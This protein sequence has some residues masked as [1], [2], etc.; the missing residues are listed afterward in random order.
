MTHPFNKKRFW[1][2]IAILAV[3]EALAF[4][5]VMQ[6]KY[7]F[8]SHEV[9]EIYTSYENVKGIDVSFIKDFQVNDTLFVDVTVLEATTDSAWD[10]LKR[11]FVLTEAINEC[12]DNTDIKRIMAWRA[13]KGKP[14]EHF[15]TKKP[16][17]WGVAVIPSKKSVTIFHNKN[18]KENDVVSYYIFQKMI[19]N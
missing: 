10:E 12:D 17:D 1:L 15:K 11:D 18:E 2:L 13:P 4:F 6:W 5:L 19:F 7:F 14:A 8:P 3:V 16:D 9:S